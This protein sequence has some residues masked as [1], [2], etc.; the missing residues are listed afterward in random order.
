MHV[1]VDNIV[2]V[3]A[4]ETAF[5]QRLWV[6]EV[7]VNCHVLLFAQQRVL[8][9]HSCHHQVCMLLC[10]LLFGIYAQAVRQH[11]QQ[12]SLDK[13]QLSWQDLHRAAQIAAWSGL[14]YLLPDELQAAIQQ[15]HKGLNLVAAGRNGYTSW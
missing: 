2:G 10:L 4:Y 13:Q 14:C 8:K 3:W 15:Q 6:E 9:P 12:Q 7:V 5:L 11:Q 1:G